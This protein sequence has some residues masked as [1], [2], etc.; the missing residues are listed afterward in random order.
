VQGLVSLR[1]QQL[2]SSDLLSA[3][4]SKE[5]RLSLVELEAKKRSRLIRQWEKMSQEI[6]SAQKREELERSRRQAISRQK[7]QLPPARRRF[8]MRR[9]APSVF[10]SDCLDTIRPLE[11][12]E[13]SAD[14]GQLDDEADDND[15]VACAAAAT[16]RR[17]TKSGLISPR[18]RPQGPAWSSAQAVELPLG[19]RR[20][21]LRQSSPDEGGGSVA[22]RE[23]EATEGKNWLVS[24]CG[25]LPRAVLVKIGG[26][27]SAS[28][29][30]K[31]PTANFEPHTTD[32]VA[33]DAASNN[34]S[35]NDYNDLRP[36]AQEE[37]V[38][39]SEV[40]AFLRQRRGSTVQA[41]GF[42]IPRLTITASPDPV[43]RRGRQRRV[44]A[45]EGVNHTS[46][47]DEE[48]EDERNTKSLIDEE[49]SS[50]EEKEDGDG[51]KVV[52]KCRSKTINRGAPSSILR[53]L[54]TN[55]ALSS[56]F[57]CCTDDLAEPVKKQGWLI[58]MGD[59]LFAQWKKRSG[60][61]SCPPLWPGRHSEWKAVVPG[62]WCWSTPS[63]CG[64]QVPASRRKT[65]S[66]CGEA[67]W[68][69]RL[70]TGSRVSSEQVEAFD[71]V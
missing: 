70:P 35:C 28:D 46:S 43:P 9:R 2:S 16:F 23:Q 36:E 18:T 34:D 32:A 69:T 61:N 62:G 3:P 24:A 29:Q 38:A 20:G 17:L 19:S 65:A 57:F 8:P 49:Y 4:T 6:E 41:S 22:V 27:P 7:S 14:G 54:G 21:G 12:H 47:T 5:R 33:H 60:S 59:G 67:A 68:W 25:R 71:A 11:D 30:T 39:V 26:R 51:V 50:E 52:V 45:V 42:A 13:A 15:G 37:R 44:K 1:L 55:V 63:S 58:K 56:W 64:V 40:E 53:A 66:A 10:S 48:G 31:K